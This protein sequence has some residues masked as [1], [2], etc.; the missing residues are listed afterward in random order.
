MQI[1]LGMV[2]VAARR[3]DVGHFL[4]DISPFGTGAVLHLDGI[5]EFEPAT[6]ARIGHCQI[7]NSTPYW[8]SFLPARQSRPAQNFLDQTTSINISVPTSLRCT[9]TTPDPQAFFEIA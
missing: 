6:M 8:Q 9:L 4:N 5:K 7:K 1:P 2:G 3:T